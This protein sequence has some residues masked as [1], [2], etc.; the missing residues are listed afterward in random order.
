VRIF[1]G[2][3]QHAEREDEG[4]GIC[5]PQKVIDSE[6]KKMVQWKIKEQMFS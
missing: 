3:S 6:R 5:G 2:S 4:Y 1:C